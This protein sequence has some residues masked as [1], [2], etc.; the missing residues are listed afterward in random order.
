MK[1]F[2]RILSIVLVCAMV[3]CVL[4][5]CTGSGSGNGG[6]SSVSSSTAAKEIIA[7]VNSARK[8]AGKNEFT[9]SAYLTSRAEK[10]VALYA[11][12][13]KNEITNDEWQQKS[14]EL[15]PISGAKGGKFGTYHSGISF[16]NDSYVTGLSGTYIG[17][18][19]ITT[20]GVTYYAFFVGNN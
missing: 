15:G 3:L 6:N 10:E 20:N 19:T 4:T 5:A 14:N 2:K 11:S 12:F 16:V 17:C 7:A 18:A 1:T 8:A 9:E 13:M